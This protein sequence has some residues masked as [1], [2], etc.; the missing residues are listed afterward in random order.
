MV[1]GPEGQSLTCPTCEHQVILSENGIA[2]VQNDLRARHLLEER[3][4]CTCGNDCEAKATR[5]CRECKIFLCQA[6]TTIHQKWAAFKHHQVST[7]EIEAKPQKSL[8]SGEEVKTDLDLDLTQLKKNFLEVEQTLQEYSEIE[9]KI[10]NHSSKTKEN[11]DGKID[12]LQQFLEER[13]VSLKDEV[14]N[15][16]ESWLATQR[17]SVRTTHENMNR[18]L[19]YAKYNFDNGTEDEVVAMKT[20]IAERIQYLNAE[21]NPENIK[22]PSRQFCIELVTDEQ[23]SRA[24]Q[25]FGEIVYDSISPENS[26]ATGDGTKFAIKDTPTTVEVHPM[27]K[28]NEKFTRKTTPTGELVSKSA[29]RKTVTPIKCLQKEGKYTITYTPLSRGTCSLHIRI[30]GKDIQGSPFSIPV[31]P[32]LKAV[33]VV[34]DLKGE[35]AEKLDRPYRAATNSKG[36][37][38]VGDFIANEIFKITT[39]GEVLHK[40]GRRGTENGEVRQPCGVAIDEDDNIYVA[41]NEN[42]R[43]QKFDSNGTFIDTVGC[44]GNNDLE[45]HFP[46]G[47]CFNKT[48]HNLYICDQYNHR[49]QVITTDLKFV[50]CFGQEGRGNGQLGRPKYAAFDDSNNLY[51]TDYVNNRVQVFTA[52]GEFLRIISKKSC[53][54]QLEKPY[55]IAIDSAN[56]VYVSERGRNCIS[57]LTSEGE[58]IDSFGEEGKEKGKLCRVYGLSIGENDS[59]VVSEGG[60]C[61]IQIFAEEA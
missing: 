6:C 38:I 53:D 44:E 10:N 52:D 20:L 40:F 46:L 4:F 27:S 17:G 41:D 21:F 8:A 29:N 12:K 55:G 56:I 25:E 31:A 11:I 24:C 28:N 48:D 16:T 42:N 3:K 18:C 30:D 23:A 2:G 9:N 51:V 7:N 5:Y 1:Q 60:N 54:Q 13:R 50:R 61:R 37:L 59:L 39:E 14:D 15:H 47:I 58:F 49:I 57:M 45:F 22:P 36:Q 34:P 26:Y 32:S 43:I 35:Q 19:N 33:K